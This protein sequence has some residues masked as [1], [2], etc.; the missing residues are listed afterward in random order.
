MI[1]VRAVHFECVPL[2]TDKQL[3][4]FCGLCD[5]DGRAKIINLLNLIFVLQHFLFVWYK[6]KIIPLMPSLMMNPQSLILFRQY[7]IQFASANNFDDVITSIFGSEVEQN[8]LQEIKKQWLTDD[9][10]IVPLIEI[11]TSAELNGSY[12]AFSKETGKI[13]L[14]QEFLD[15]SSS[16]TIATILLEEYGHLIDAKLNVVDSP[17]DEGA[18]FSSFVQGKTLGLDRLQQLKTEDDRST[19]ILDSQIIEVE[20]ASISDGGGEG[21]TNQQ[22]RLD[23][24][25]AGQTN[26]GNVTVEYFYQHYTIPDQFTLLYDGKNI[27]D[28]G[29]LV[30]GSRS[31]KVTFARGNSDFITVKVTAPRTGTAWDFS[32]TT[33]NDLCPDTT[34]F[35][36]QAVG[37]T[38]KDNDGDGDCEYS[39]TVT[40]G[41]TDGISKLIRIEGGMVEYDKTKVTVTGGTIYSQI[42]NV[43]GP[44]FHGDFIIPFNTGTTTSLT[45]DKRNNAGDLRLAGLDVNLVSLSLNRDR[46][47][48]GTRFKLPSEIGVS[49]PDISTPFDT[50]SIKQSGVGLGISG[51]LSLNNPPKQKFSFFG[52]FDVESSDLSLE[53]IAAEDKLKL[54]G[55]FALGSFIKD[56]SAKITADLAG[57]NFIE[58]KDGK[59]DVKGSLTIATGITTSSGWGLNELAL[60]IDTKQKDV[61]GSTK[62][63]FP[64]KGSISEVDLGVGFKLP[65][66]PLELNKVSINVDNLNV[67]IPAYPLVFF[68][69]FAGAVENFAPSDTDPIEFSGGVGA[70]LGPQFEASINF[71]Q[72]GLSIDTG[73]VAL[74]RLDVDGK[75][76]STELS[77]TGKI[78]VLSDKLFTGTGTTKFNWNDKFLEQSGTFSL[79]DGLFKT[80]NSFK[81]DS[82]WNINMGGKANVNI[83]SFIDVFGGKNL[84]NA[85]FLLN[86]TNNSTFSDDYA[87]VW[88]TLRETILGVDIDIPLGFRAFFDGRLELIA[89]GGPPSGQALAPLSGQ[90]IAGSSLSTNT[91]LEKSALISSNI[92]APSGAKW[93]LLTADWE[94]SSASTKI[95][96]KK[97]DGTFIEES[98]FAANNIS[99]FN[100][101]NN[102]DTRAAVVINPTPG[103][104]SVEVVD[105]TGLGKVSYTTK[106]D[107]VAP[108]VQ[109]TSPVSDL[110]SEGAVTIGYSAFD[111]DSTANIKLFYDNNDTGLDGILIKDGLIENDGTGSFTW[112]TEGIPTGEY[113]IYAMAMDNE[114]APVYSSYSKGKVKAVGSADLS[115]D[116]VISSGVAV[117][118]TDFTY[119]ITVKNNGASTAKDVVLNDALSSDVKFVSASKSPDAQQNNNLTFNLGDILSGETKTI[120]V[121]V[122]APSSSVRTSNTV[123]VT[124][125]T[126][127]P[128][129]NNNTSILNTLVE[130]TP[131][132][133]TDL[134]L[135]V[136]STN[137]PLKIGDKITYDFTVTNNGN[138]TATGIKVKNYLPS[139]LQNL[140]FGS[141]ANSSSIS[142]KDLKAGQSETISIAGNTIAAGDLTLTS[143]VESSSVDN[144]ES[145]NSIILQNTV[146]AATPT[147]SDLELSLS[148]DKSTVKAGED[149]TLEIMLF[150]KGAG[151]ATAIQVKDLLP[152]GLAFV[153]FSAQQGSYDSVT[154]IWNAGNIAKDN[155]A[156][157][158]I[159]ANVKTGG[160]I[161]NMAEVISVSEID[162]DSTPGNNNLTEDDIASVTIEAKPLFGIQKATEDAWTVNGN[163]K[164]KVALTGKNSNQLNEIGVFKLAAD[165]TVNGIAVG[166]AGFAQAA[167]ANSTTLFTA[168]PDQTTDGL[169]LSRIFNVADGDRLGF[170]M[171]ANGTIEEDLKYNNFNN[172]VFS[173]DP[174]NPGSKDYLQVTE[175]AG[176]FTLNWEQGNDN[177]FQDLSIRLTTDSSPDSPLS[178]ISNL[179][180]KPAG[181]ILDLRAFDGQNLQATFTVKREAFYNNIAGF[182]KIDDVEGTVTSLT[183]AKLKPTD[184]GYKQAAL[185]NKIAGLDL[186]GENNK[187]ITIDKN[188]T[189]GSMYAS[190]LIINGITGFDNNLVYT[191]FSQ[192]NFAGVDRVRLLGENTFGFEDLLINSDNDFN[193]FIVQASFKIV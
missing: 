62:I 174:A 123:T 33:K 144:N 4:N 116:S 41:R 121:I 61:G 46:I 114:N 73:R 88:T 23:P 155:T 37:G 32:V 152:Q 108:T 136:V 1:C 10:S 76:S 94:N 93:I 79:I 181:E 53:Y 142:F 82:S 75:I 101:L 24:L 31:G 125:K 120:D 7:L 8:Q 15:Y 38:F 80:S 42:G 153:S 14:S 81:V 44:L 158:S 84:T 45:D 143:V 57:D 146:E 35:D 30:S 47:G 166:T 50:I 48:L 138:D 16:E 98:D 95:R 189:G 184:K 187:T 29:G 66:P 28:T 167:L 112:N 128:S 58:I 2:L 129:I 115:I 74:I 22:L 56:S 157:L 169:D 91:L 168:L 149:V 60:N 109:I 179:Q 6:Y 154:G 188:I 127:D 160:T 69:R 177:T 170:F 148:V 192:S 103:V 163:G 110:T 119:K 86:Y 52:L 164:V 70:T 90:E 99:L 132:I 175:K 131:V 96:I 122:K 156:S 178:S 77:G 104:W 13:Y 67:P 107:S 105:S 63:T 92:A 11:R 165:N 161:I 185:D 100:A 54:Q 137:T 68:Q 117:T 5:W 20:E 111:L 72:I 171:V 97:P 182:Y 17:G 39:G 49:I 186:V 134:S 147:P 135:A 140:V 183:G 106:K 36:I 180:G 65:I 102:S 21:G 190:Y 25:P 71:P 59:A 18:I 162:P 113:F 133:S 19:I 172:V 78:T 118:N 193:D 55:K 12:G 51:K 43:T 130:A 141:G 83:P 139:E 89:S 85:D 176:A 27:F 40:I 151:A 159:K 150:N 9:F 3:V 191:S 87:A 26:K 173:I 126:F 64:F 145:N 124:S 34:P